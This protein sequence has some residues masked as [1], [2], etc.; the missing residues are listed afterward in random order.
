MTRQPTR[1][2]R[3]C[4]LAALLMLC[5]GCGTAEQAPTACPLPPMPTPAPGTDSTVLAESVD[6]RCSGGD[7]SPAAAADLMADA[8]AKV[9]VIDTR[10]PAEYQGGHLPGAVNLSTQDA[11]FWDEVGTL[12]SDGVY[13]LYCRTGS[14]TRRIL[15]Q[16]LAMGFGNVCHIESGFNGWV[17]DG[18]PVEK[19]ES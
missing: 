11:S 17:R 4:A 6:P 3:A 1:Q 13:I 14:A 18:F 5:A 15:E 10:T 9:T 7:L 2:Y 8:E 16:M 12:P 19:E